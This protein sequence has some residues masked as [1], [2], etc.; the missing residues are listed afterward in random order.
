MECPSCDNQ[1]QTFE[2]SGIQLDS[3]NSCGGVWFDNFELKKLREKK[4]ETN[5][6]SFEL[7]VEPGTY[8]DRDRERICPKCT[9]IKMRRHFYGPNREI[10][11]DTCA[12]CNGM[13]LDH[14]EFESIKET[15]PTEEDRLA[16]VNKMIQGQSH[17]AFATLKAQHEEDINTIKGIQ[18]VLTHILPKWML[19]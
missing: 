6:L 9:N 7:K 15:Y 2:S 18:D 10:E 3:C 8:I 14:G 13:W 16:A 12:G 19:K 11:V 5:S 4:S 1:L 17:E